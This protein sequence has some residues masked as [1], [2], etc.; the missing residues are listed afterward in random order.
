MSKRY[1]TRG[2]SIHRSYNIEEAARAVGVHVQTVRMW[3]KNSLPCLQDK[4]PYLILGHHLIE[5][6]A[7]LN[8]RDKNPLQDNQLY[9]LKCRKGITPDGDMA[10]FIPISDG[11][12]RLTGFC[13]TCETLCN[14]F[15]SLGQIA[16]IASGLEVSFQTG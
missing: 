2:I 7:Q 5:Y 14:R 3:T 13:P 16:T 4:K 12:G 15:V 10:D 11:K 6:I 8:G 1:K 9:C